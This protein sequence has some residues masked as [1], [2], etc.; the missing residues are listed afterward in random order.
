MAEKF[1]KCP[2]IQ[3]PSN[4]LSSTGNDKTDSFL[5]EKS[6]S[7]KIA[8]TKIPREYKVHP[9]IF[10]QKEKRNSMNLHELNLSY[11]GIKNNAIYKSHKIGSTRL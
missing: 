4:S 7:P 6:R 1:Q 10:V 5:R 2:K 9:R 8:L 11:N 3:K